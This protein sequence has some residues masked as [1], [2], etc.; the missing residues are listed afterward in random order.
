MQALD[1]STLDALVKKVGL[2]RDA[3]KTPLAG[4]RAALLDIASRL[5]RQ[6]FF[7][8]D[9][10]AHD[11]RFWERVLSTLTPGTLLLF[12]LGFLHFTVFAQLC[13]AGV[14][15]ITRAKHNTVCRAQQRLRESPG[16][17]DSLVFVGQGA[18]RCDCLLG[19][20]EVPYRGQWYRS[21]TNV[22]APA[23]LPSEVVVA[24]YWQRCVSKTLFTASN[25]CWDGPIFMSAR[26]TAFRF[27]SGVR[28]CC[29]RYGWPC[30][31]K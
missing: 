15:F 5:P 24:L 2:L 3:P 23:I 20:V 30:A 22:T 25:A 12:D 28:G 29:T 18:S 21:L 27:R 1:G 9:T 19:L 17:R 26:L 14:G 13:K 10:K 31:P 6:I 4:R 11:Q 8:E 16:L 7:E